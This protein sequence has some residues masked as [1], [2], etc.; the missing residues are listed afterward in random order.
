MVHTCRPPFFG[1]KKA[2]E[3]DECM[4][5]RERQKPKT[6]S[7]NPH[8]SQGDLLHEKTP[9]MGNDMG[10]SANRMAIGAMANATH[11][12]KKELLRLQVSPVGRACIYFANGAKR[13][14]FLLCV[15]LARENACCFWIR[16]PNPRRSQWM[17]TR[18][19]QS[20]SLLLLVVSPCSGE[21]RGQCTRKGNFFRACERG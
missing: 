2:V 14:F 15:L 8:H 1:T 5:S 7:L 4:A 10:R 12:E 20:G 17:A 13:S 21:R 16:K 3:R 18:P 6:A 19:S 11:F 9:K